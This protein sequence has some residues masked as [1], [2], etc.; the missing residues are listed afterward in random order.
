MTWNYRVI[1]H[2]QSR[3]AYFAVHEVYYDEK[4][5]VQSWTAESVVIVG[6]SKQ[7][8][9]KTLEYIM[10]DVRHPVL[11]ESELDKKTGKNWG[12]L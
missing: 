10:A 8:V 5:N 2:D 1:K 7:E 6:D 11:K 4:G 12:E 3:P 9:M